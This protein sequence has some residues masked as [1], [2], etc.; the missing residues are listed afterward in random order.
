M[1]SVFM[2]ILSGDILGVGYAECL[3]ADCHYI[4]FHYAEDCISQCHNFFC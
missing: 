2:L 4:V 3:R 1:L